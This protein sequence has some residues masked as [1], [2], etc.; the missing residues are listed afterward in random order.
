MTII[1]AKV[2]GLYLLGVGIA[3]ALNPERFVRIYK[4]MVRNESVLLL[5][6]IMALMFG[7][8]II[9]VH[10]IWIWDWPVL[11]TILGWISLVKGFTLLLVS[12]LGKR[13]A[14]L[15]ENSNGFYRALGLFWIVVGLF[16]TYQGWKNTP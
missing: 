7:A 5:G 10:N 6:A 14:Y 12:D 4:E 15:Y 8:F 1:L 11:I 2:F 3:L 13:F 9:S 16:L